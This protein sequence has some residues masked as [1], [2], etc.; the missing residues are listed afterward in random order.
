MKKHHDPILHELANQFKALPPFPESDPS[1]AVALLEAGVTLRHV[2]RFIPP[3]T[4]F[5]VRYFIRGRTRFLAY[6]PQNRLDDALRFADAC[7]L[8]FWKYRR[9][10]ASETP[11]ASQFNFS[12]EAAEADLADWATNRPEIYRLITDIEDHLLAVDVFWDSES[13]M[14]QTTEKINRRTIRGELACIHQVMLELQK[15]IRDDI[16]ELRSTLTG[17][18]LPKKD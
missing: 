12:R 5:G 4:I 2:A 18:F 3:S 8:Q 14:T 11:D 7:T 9:R 6:A 17:Q 1:R 13:Q 10:C 15:E 16:A